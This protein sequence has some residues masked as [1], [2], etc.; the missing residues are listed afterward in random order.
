MNHWERLQA[1]VAGEAVDRAPISLWRHWPE[2]D[3]DPAALAKAMVDWQRTYDFDLVKYMPTGTYSIEDWGARTVYKPTRNGTRTVTQFGVTDVGE[4][5]RL[6]ALDGISGYMGW[7]NESLRIAAEAL[8]GTV[9]ILQ[10]VFSP[11]TTARKLAG[12]VVFEHMRTRPELLEAGLA[13]IAR[14]SAA[15]AREAIRCGA[16]GLFFATQCSTTDVMTEAEYLRFG[17]PFD[18]TV[19]DAVKDSARFNLMHV[20]GENTMFD[21][22]AGYPVDML[23]WHDRRTAPSLAEGAQRFAGLLVGGID[24][25]RTLLNADARAIAAEI[26]DAKRQ[27]SAKR[28]MLAPG[29]VCPIE[30]P[31]ASVR[32][33]VDA[34]RNVDAHFC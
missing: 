32:A 33:A 1:A 19:L 8:G 16:S 34:V 23:N 6:A 14:T 10:T 27:T 2:I 5:P 17:K 31:A 29:C 30:T 3:Q 9:P 4:W 12:D 11:L 26:D 20:H 7:Q 21:L 18:L 22:M 25:W 15:F 13:I 24:E 28:L